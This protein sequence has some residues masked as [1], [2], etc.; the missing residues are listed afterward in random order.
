[1]RVAEALIVDRAM[2]AA[3]VQ[4]WHL[5]IDHIRVIHMLSIRRFFFLISSKGVRT[6]IALLSSLTFRVSCCVRLCGELLQVNL[7]LSFNVL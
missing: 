1:M 3:L 7:I 5:D 2:M 6:Y 4:P